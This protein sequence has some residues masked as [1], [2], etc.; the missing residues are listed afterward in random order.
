MKSITLRYYCFDWDDNLLS[1][2]TKINMEHLINGK[3]IPTQ[4]STEMFAKI[5]NEVDKWKLGEEPFIEFR[6]YGPRGDN[7]FIDD[8]K[9]AIGNSIYPIPPK[10]KASYSWDKFIESICNASLVSII[11]ARGHKPETLRKGVELIIDDYLT[12]DQKFELYNNCKKFEYIF[13]DN[14]NEELPSYPFDITDVSNNNYVKIWLDNCGFYPVSNE[15]FV[16]KY[17]SG[18]AES[19]EVGKE[20]AL[21]EFLEKGRSYAIKIGANFEAGMSD[22]DM[23]NVLHMKTVLSELKELYPENK[24]SLINTSNGNYDKEVIESYTKTPGLGGSV[25]SFSKWNSMNQDLYVSSKDRPADAYHNRFKNQVGQATDLGYNDNDKKE[26]NKKV[27]EYKGYVYTIGN[28]KGYDPKL[29]KGILYKSVGGSVWKRYSDVLEYYK[30]SK[31]QVDGKDVDSSIYVVEADW[32]K[33]V[34]LIPGQIYGELNKN[35]KI[36]KKRNK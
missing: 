14:I 15:E 3:W 24:Y 36:I 11:T 13:K 7:A 5:R 8:V 34:N 25:M 1:M 19:P 21:K 31:V 16:E 33:D 20:I 17:K 4:V 30:N 22:D 18:G 9:Q 35:C 26:Y 12:D 23:K 2:P 29:E 10:K 32:D 28:T 6:D 27:K